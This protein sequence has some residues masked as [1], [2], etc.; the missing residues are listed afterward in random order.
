MNE[1]GEERNRKKAPGFHEGEEV[2][3]G[4]KT[5]KQGALLAERVHEIGNCGYGTDL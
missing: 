2:K 1:R 5:L 3:K 4:K